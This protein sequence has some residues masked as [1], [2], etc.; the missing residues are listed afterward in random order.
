MALEA[1]VFS[2]GLFGSWA[3]MASAPGG[4]G[5]WSWGHGEN[6]HPGA[7]EG[8]M[9]L[10]VGSAAAAAAYWELGASSSM[11]MQEADHELHGSCSAPPPPPENG[12]NSAAGAEAVAVAAAAAMSP[13]QQQPAGRRKRR[14]TRSV[15][16]REEV[17]SQRMTHIAVE[18]NRRKQMNEYL[19]VLRSLM[20]PSYVQRGDQASII[21]GAINYV[22]ELEQ[23]LQSLEARRH[24]RRRRHLSPGDDDAAAAAPFAGFFTF[25]QYSM[26]ARSSPAAAN[27]PPADDDGGQGPKNAGDEDD[28]GAAD[29]SG[30][31]RPSSVA[32]IEVTMVESHANLKLL[33][34]RHPR[35]LLRLVAGLHGHRLTVLHLNA[36]SDDAGDTALYSLSLKVEDDCA[37]SSVDDIAAA[38][39]RIVEGVDQEEA[40]CADR[41]RQIVA[42]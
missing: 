29:S 39:H 26:S 5:G 35:Q 28:D 10:E 33:S 40:A 14:R 23:L 21:G 18:R 4:G 37:L 36:T 34:R 6:E 16:N 17:E 9:D 41:A 25:P 42:G 13:A 11:V 38:V 7:M 1:V 19:A 27:T 31:S 2:E 3:S 32:E 30:R 15:K 12:G 8:M 24:T 20:P 22:K